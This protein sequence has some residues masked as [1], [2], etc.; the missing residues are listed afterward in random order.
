MRKHRNFSE[1]NNFFLQHR[2]LV[3]NYYFSF[4]LVHAVKNPLLIVKKFWFSVL[5]LLDNKFFTTA[6]TPEIFAPLHYTLDM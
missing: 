5:A 4:S 1:K 2:H 6:K 3:K